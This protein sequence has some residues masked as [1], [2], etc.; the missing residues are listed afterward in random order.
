V[1]DISID[2]IIKSA[3]A[4]K[5][6]DQIKQGQIKQ[7]KSEKIKA[8]IAGGHA[9][10][11]LESAYFASNDQLISPILVGPIKKTKEIL[12]QMGMDDKNFCFIEAEGDENIAEKMV[13]VT[14][15]MKAGMVIKGQIHTD[16]FMGALVRKTANLRTDK[17]F[18]HIF[19]MN[20]P[21]F[22][23]PL[24]ISDAALNISPKGE[25]GRAILENMVTLAHATGIDTPN[26]AVLSATEEVNQAMETSLLAKELSDW[27]MTYIKNANIRG[28]LAFDNAISLEA[29]RIKGLS[30]S[31]VGMADGLLVPSIEA[32]NILFKSLVYL[33]GA[34]AAGI[35][36]GAK[37]PIILTSRA[38]SSE[39][40]LI[41]FL[42]AILCKN[43]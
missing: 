39:S 30:G 14:H 18:T 1:S 13:E 36:L 28:P 15:D 31:V 8:V 9:Q 3:D 5:L 43:I 37:I 29:A 20:I 7:E 24:L 34:T 41:S 27:G 10:A 23:R 25:T 2:K 38:D 17:R 32:G 21:N 42:L 26:I 12:T 33:N 6:Y 11:V 35:V 22:P 16:K 40:R 19:Y 4:R